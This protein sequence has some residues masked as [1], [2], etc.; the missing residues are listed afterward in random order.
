MPSLPISRLLSSGKLAP[1]N[2]KDASIS[3]KRLKPLSSFL[4]AGTPF[5]RGVEPGSGAYNPAGKFRFLRNSCVDYNNISEQADKL[6]RLSFLPVGCSPLVRYDVLLCKDANIGEA[7]LF[8]G[9]DERPT[10]FSSGVVRLRF[11]NEADRLFCLAFIRTDFF[12]EQLNAL[13]P[14]GSTIR[15]AGRLFLD[16]LIPELRPDELWVRDALAAAIRN[17]AHAETLCEEKLC[18]AAGIFDQDYDKFAFSYK[19]PRASSLFKQGR[20]DA[21]FYSEV[22]EKIELWVEQQ[23]GGCASI[24]QFGF[25]MKRGPNLQKRDMGRSIQ[26]TT[27]RPGYHALVYPSSISDH[28]YIEEIVYLGARALVWHIERGG[29][30]FSAE[31]TVGKTFCVCDDTVSFITN[32]HGLI[33]HPLA[34]ELPRERSAFLCMYFHYL[35]RK[36]YFDKISVGGQGGSLALRY[37]DKVKIPIFDETRMKQIA[38]KYDADAGEMDPAVFDLELL[39]RAGVYQ[40]NMF[41]M[42]C[43]SYIEELVSKVLGDDP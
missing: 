35:R 9:T 39:Q 15:H 7:A 4:E 8:M 30:L 37:W 24:K 5:D 25:K 6:E 32:I 27:L 20:L 43:L 23:P 21:G 17:V 26:R 22:V 28:G 42:R 33:F 38:S 2:Y 41:R 16:C 19:N 34:E 36:G 18:E 3:R 12:K 10:V 14:R 1:S 31:G 13:T 40:L 11:A 29:V